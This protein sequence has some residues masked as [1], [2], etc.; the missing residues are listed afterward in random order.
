VRALLA[1]LLFAGPLLGQAANGWA[2]IEN[3][4]GEVQIPSSTSAPSGLTSGRVTLSTGASTVGDDAGLTGVGTG[5]GFKLGIGT[6]VFLE[7][8][9]AQT[10]WVTE[11]AGGS[12][13]LLIRQLFAENGVLVSP[14]GIYGG[15]A[16]KVGWTNSAYYYGTVDLAI[17]RASAGTLLVE[18]GSGNARDVQARTGTFG[19]S[20][21]TPELAS[22]TGTLKLNSGAGSIYLSATDLFP[23][24][25]NAYDFGQSAIPWRTGY[26]G[27]SL[28]SPLLSTAPAASGTNIAGTNMTI[29]PQAGT[30]SATGSSIIFQTP[31][32]TGSGT[33]GQTQTTRLT[34]SEP[35][36]IAAVPVRLKGY[37]VAT[38][39]AGTVGDMAYCT[40]LTAPTFM[41]V[42][43]GGGAV[44]GKVFYDGTNWITQ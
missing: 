39:P 12:R 2:P 27:T 33:T 17:S 35:A 13:D 28:Y 10:L 11:G 25:A 21:V 38:L 29:Q 1:L 34:L 7:R 4:W 44:V 6:D 16:T 22:T 15:N 14:S 26:F 40:D 37:T 5:T 24:A 9:A 30:G 20:V 3:G 43:V 31:T 32:A 8:Y 19:T 18:D 36:V 42:A 23:N 41:A